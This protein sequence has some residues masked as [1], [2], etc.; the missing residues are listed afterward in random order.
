M[1]KL[2]I[3]ILMLAPLTTFGNIIT[4]SDLSIEATQYVHGRSSLLDNGYE[5]KYGLN[6]NMSTRVSRFDYQRIRVTSATDDRQFRYVALEAE[7]GF[8]YNGVD[9]YIKHK[10]QH[11]L[12]SEYT[13]GFRDDNEVGIRL[14][15]Y[16]EKR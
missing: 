14:N 11:L 1:S 5:Q 4:L 13:N 12:D 16:K 8:T 2:Y 6:L 10:S 7:H 3:I 9:V 15:L